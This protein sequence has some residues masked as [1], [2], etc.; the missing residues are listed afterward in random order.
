MLGQA[1]TLPLVAILICIVERGGEYFFVYL[2]A[3]VTLV[4]ILLMTVYPDHIAPLFDT[5]I[6]LPQSELRTQIEAL[7]ASIDFPL[8][9]SE[10]LYIVEGSERALKDFPSP[11]MSNRII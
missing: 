5:Y 8:R 9:K 4:I 10:N 11:P 6:P 1:I 2:W 3:F 7:A